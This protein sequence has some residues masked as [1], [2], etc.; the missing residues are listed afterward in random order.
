MFV[1]FPCF[2]PI[3]HG[4]CTSARIDSMTKHAFSHNRTALCAVFLLPSQPK[5]EKVELFQIGCPRGRPFWSPSSYGSVMAEKNS[6]LD[7]DLQATTSGV[8]DVMRLSS[9]I[10]SGRTLYKHGV[11]LLGTKWN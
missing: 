2:L 1:V 11:A 6:G 7:L 5:Q 4:D 8:E 3:F 10:F 9:A